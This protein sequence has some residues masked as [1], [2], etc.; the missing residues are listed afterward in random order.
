MALGIAVAVVAL[1]A[2]SFGAGRVKHP[3]NLK[4]AA[5]KAELLKIEAELKADEQKLVAE[6]KGA[7]A[8]VVARIKSLL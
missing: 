7:Y 3:A 6:A 1:V 2:L 4:V 8:A 5:V